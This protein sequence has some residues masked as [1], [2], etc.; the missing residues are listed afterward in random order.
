MHRSYPTGLK[1]RHLV[2]KSIRS[3]LGRR[4]LPYNWHAELQELIL[5]VLVSRSVVLKVLARYGDVKVKTRLNR[6]SELLGMERFDVARAHKQFVRSALRGLNGRDLCL[7]LGRAVLIADITEYAK[8]RSRGKDEPMPNTGLVRLKNIP[9]DDVALVPGYQE[10]WAGLL[11]RQGN[12]LGIERR[13]FSEK[14]PFFTSQNLLT[15][16]TIRDAQDLIKSTLSRDTIL[17]V[18][19]GFARKE[20][21]AQMSAD[22][23]NSFILRL[24]G[25]WNVETLAGRFGAL[26]DISGAFVER[27]RMYWRED[28]K[29]PLFCSVRAFPVRIAHEG[30]S[31]DVNIL[32]IDSRTD[33]RPPI[34]L[35]TTLPITTLE[36]VSMIVKLYSKRWTIETF[37]FQFK[38]SLGA[39]GF[40]V[41]GSWRTMDRLL[42]V[43]HM[44][45][46]TLQILYLTARKRHK[47][48]WES[49][50]AVLARWSIRPG[51]MILTQLLEAI[52]LDFI[53]DRPAW[54]RP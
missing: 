24:Q 2:A 37:F 11:L 8:P 48:F 18:D 45:M 28:S 14:A 38:Q 15:D 32:R 53:F 49:A 23:S 5:A 40:R 30:A 10:I 12:C 3:C 9:G 20:I 13:L 33:G 52:A 27:L 43:A 19:R 6:L 47:Q 4:F 51:E 25:N 26:E 41:F 36:E 34:F 1:S 17:V 54:I 16:A 7:Y 39:G 42:A 46:L 22:K 35:V 50:V 44:A 29:V 21:V 31:F